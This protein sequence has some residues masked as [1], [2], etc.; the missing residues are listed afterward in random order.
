MAQQGCPGAFICLEVGVFLYDTMQL[1]DID[2]CPPGVMCIAPPGLCVMQ[3]FPPGL[4]EH[5]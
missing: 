4:C 5:C 3:M 1:K 2:K